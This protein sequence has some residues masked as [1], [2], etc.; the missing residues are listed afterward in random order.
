MV[1]FTFINQMTV[2]KSLGDSKVFVNISDYLKVLMTIT[3]QLIDQ[4]SVD[5]PDFEKIENILLYALLSDY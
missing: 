3:K 1:D 2:E 4:N 5:R